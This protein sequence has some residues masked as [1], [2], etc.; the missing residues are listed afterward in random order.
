VAALADKLRRL[1]GTL[2]DSSPGLLNPLVRGCLHSSGQGRERTSG[3]S[4]ERRLIRA[5]YQPVNAWLS[6]SEHQ[7][8]T[9]RLVA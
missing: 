6:R 8:Q 9:T 4:H 2:H 3:T 5:G 1:I 7:N